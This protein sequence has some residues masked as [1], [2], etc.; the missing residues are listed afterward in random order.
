[1][2]AATWS[3]NSLAVP[4]NFPCSLSATIMT[5]YSSDDDDRKL[6]SSSELMRDDFDFDINHYNAH[7]GFLGGS[8]ESKKTEKQQSKAESRQIVGGS[9]KIKEGAVA[10]VQAQ[11]NGEGRILCRICGD[12]AVRHVHYGGHCCFSCKAF[13]RRA[14]NWQNKNNRNFQCKFESKCEITIKNRKTCQA[15]RFKKC[16]TTGMNPS[17]VL[18]DE[19]RKKRFKKYRDNNDDTELSPASSQD[20]EREV[21]NGLDTSRDT[22]SENYV[23]V[24]HRRRAKSAQEPLHRLI[25]PNI[26][27]PKSPIS[28]FPR[29]NR[30]S[31]PPMM[32]IAVPVIKMEKEQFEMSPLRDDCFSIDFNDQ[33]K[34][35]G[36]EAI[37]IEPDIDLDLCLNESL[38]ELMENYPFEK[39]M[40]VKPDIKNNEKDFSPTVASQPP[41]VPNGICLQLSEED[42]MHIYKIEMSFENSNNSIPVMSEET[43]EIWNFISKSCDFN[44]LSQSFTSNLLTEAVEFSLRRNLIFL[45]ENSDF[46]AL[47]LKD[48]KNLYSRN[49]GSMCHVRAV[50]QHT[51][52]HDFLVRGGPGL[53]Y[54]QNR[55]LL[56][57]DQQNMNHTE[58]FEIC[59]KN[60]K[61]GKIRRWNLMELPFEDISLNRP[62]EDPEKMDNY[63]LY[64]GQAGSN[65]DCQ[66]R[67]LLQLAESLWSLELERTSYLI[68]LLVVLFSSQGGQLDNLKEVDKFQNQYMML[69]FRYLQAKHGQEKVHQYLSKIM[70]F[71]L[72]LLT[73]TY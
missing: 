13:F 24:P 65:G 38:G 21:I 71:V 40:D 4:A 27:Q 70:T 17:W 51:N 43:S 18:S 45:Q 9:S 31:G 25:S 22:D 14:V 50:M 54:S 28:R 52:K 48:R 66:K 56:N 6:G 34:Y 62:Y 2:S 53:V 15:C 20:S 55:T 11:T 67:S 35:L 60:H 16:M 26:C 30:L 32:G 59:Y 73:N 5:E 39:D 10:G 36:D 63:S 3:N 37:K 64:A 41:T 7:N 1:M 33:H 49:M 44:N 8:V 29:V 61:T 69:L 19:Q 47:S 72:N 58:H 46:T 68:L 12:S 42:M 23:Q 57:L